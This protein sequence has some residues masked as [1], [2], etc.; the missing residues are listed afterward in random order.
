MIRCLIESSAERADRATEQQQRAESRYGGGAAVVGGVK[1]YL[2]SG[3]S[4]GSG[5][6]GGFGAAGSHLVVYSFARLRLFA[7]TLENV[8]SK[9]T[10]RVV[11]SYT[12]WRGSP[13][14][15]GSVG[16]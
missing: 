16:A 11:M 5:G 1:P 12:W 15:I 7:R 4:F 14:E 13:S 3:G 6:G 9:P 10:H 8:S 2:G